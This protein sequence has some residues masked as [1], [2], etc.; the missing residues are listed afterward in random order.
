M[1]LV[2]L[3]LVSLPDR[4]MPKH[5]SA[6]DRSGRPVQISDAEPAPADGLDFRLHAEKQVRP[7][8]IFDLV[9]GGAV[10]GARLIAL[11]AARLPT[12]DEITAHEAAR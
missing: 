7:G 4:N 3:H 12:A 10:E 5:G 2:A 1:L 9:E 6:F 11:G 8:A